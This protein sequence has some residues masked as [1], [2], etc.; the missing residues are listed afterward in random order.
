MSARK[1]IPC[2][3]KESIDL[4]ASATV[5]KSQPELTKVAEVIFAKTPCPISNPTY[6]NTG[7]DEENALKQTLHLANIENFL[8]SDPISK[9]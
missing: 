3:A 2:S 4:K 1:Q 5:P 7:P 9:P 8:D 6:C